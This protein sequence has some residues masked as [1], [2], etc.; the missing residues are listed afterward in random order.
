MT[1]GRSLRNLQRLERIIR[2]HYKQIYVN[3][4]YNLREMEKF[5]K[6]HKLLGCPKKSEIKIERDDKYR[7]HEQLISTKETEFV[8]TKSPTKETSD[9]DDIAGG[10][11]PTFKK[12]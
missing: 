5:F 11:F 4:F 7:Q 9:S 1:E 8:A 2:K 10:F 12:K 3:L 6:R